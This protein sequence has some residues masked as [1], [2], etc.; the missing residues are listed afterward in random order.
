VASGKLAKAHT[1]PLPFW[2]KLLFSLPMTLLAL[3]AIEGLLAVCGV[4]PVTET[5][6]P[7]VGFA[8]NIPLYVEGAA[9]DGR[10][11]MTTAPN[12][13]VYFNKQQFLKRRPAGVYRVFCLGGSTTFGRPYDDT[14]SFPGWLRELLPLAC[15]KQRWEVINAGGVSYASYRVAALM[16]ELAQYDP[17]LFIVYTGHNEFLEQRT[18]PAIQAASPAR[19]R[20]EAALAKTRTYSFLNTLLKPQQRLETERHELPA[21]VDAVLDHTVCPSSYYRDE[22]LR[23]QILRHFESNACR[24]I[25]IARAHDATVVFITPASNLKDCSPFRSQH[26]DGLPPEELKQWSI[27]YER[28]KS[29]E[30]AGELE[31]ALSVYRAAQQI[32]DRFAELHHRMGSVLRRMGRLAEAA[33]LYRRALEEDVC[34]LRALNAITEILRRTG[35]QLK[36]TVIDFELMLKNDCLRNHG[37]NVPGREYFLDHVHLTIPATRLLAVYIVRG[38]TRAGVISGNGSFDDAILTRVTGQIESR[39]DPEAHAMALR[40]LAKVLNWAGK[41]YEAGPL[42]LRALETLPDDPECLFLAGAYQ[43]MV[44]EVEQAIEKY[45]KTIQLHP[46]YAEAHQL[47]GA[48]LVER[49]Q[50][51]EA[52]RHFMAVQRINPDDA[53]A[54]H[55]VGAVLSELE[56]FGEALPHYREAIRL[57]PNDAN[58]HYNLAFALAKLG[59]TREAIPHY[60]RTVKLDPKDAVAHN[61]LGELLLAEGRHDDAAEH[62]REA[63]RIRPDYA[64][65]KANLGAHP[66]Q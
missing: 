21:E 2:K 27:H 66:S 64:E 65:A 38:L 51:E 8:S 52:C 45:R 6:D 46:D 24:M 41:H 14:T 54:H 13:L 12:K 60:V 56:R 39:I 33:V 30:E 42:A 3:G 44:G 19:L 62:F 61:N 20:V 55:M 5:R 47:L 57:E 7:F 32:D 28:G 17:D 49:K 9:T 31:E 23:Q 58:I 40:N 48:A 18:Y 1:H 15:P 34:P 29:H 26:A 11:W 36:V 25:R 22:A 50:F 59:R 63:L 10:V 53:H 35:K 37:H 4:R 16:E 43:K